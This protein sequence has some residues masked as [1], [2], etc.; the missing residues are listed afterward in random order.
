MTEPPDFT[1]E[2]LDYRLAKFTDQA[3]S[4]PEASP[5]SELADLDPNLRELG[6]VVLRLRAAMNEPPDDPR[7]AERIR[8][9]LYGEWRRT[10]HP[11]RWTQLNRRWAWGLAAGLAV[12][13]IGLG[14]VR[15]FLPDGPA[16]PAA[17][18]GEAGWAA[19]ALAGAGV[20]FA[21]A[22]LA[23]RRR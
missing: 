7:L 8:S 9:R 12:A 17:A 23:R 14:L 21:W 18:G 20:L 16:L 5:K 19:L 15:R 6:Q 1:S 4:L 13:L 2:D 22:W 11:S 3:L 10:P